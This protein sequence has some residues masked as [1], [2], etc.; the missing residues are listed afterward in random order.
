M[1]NYIKITTLSPLH[2]GAGEDFVPTGYV[3][4]QE[5]LYEF[6]ESDFY[7]ALAPA[8]KK[9]FASTASHG[10]YALKKFYEKHKDIA[11]KLAFREI[12]VSEE[13]AQ[14]YKKQYNKMAV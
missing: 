10:L 5:I 8:D 1:K 14:R 9:A 4:D 3:I 13:I 6:G 2:I 7:R 11:K 12:P